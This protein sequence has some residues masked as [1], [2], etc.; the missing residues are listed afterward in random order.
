MIEFSVVDWAA[1]APGLTERSQWMG[2]ADA[3]FL[4]HGEGTPALPEIP[5][6]QRRRIERLGRMAI[7]AA[8]WCEDGQGADSRVP[9]VFASRHG[10]VA[11]SMDL[12]GSLAASEPLSPTG[13]GLSVHNAIAAL[14]SIA[15]GHRGNYLAL[16]AGQATVEAACLEAAGL[17]ADGAPEVR[18]VV[19]ESPLPDVYAEF[20]DEPDPFFAWCWRLAAPGAAG[21]GLRLSWQAAPGAADTAPG[22]LPHALDLQRFLLGGGSSLEHVTQGQRWCWSRRG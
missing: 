10:D 14:Y 7:Q 15:R 8:C 2:W 1:W 4:P 22:L 17:L 19:Y 13:F 6:M 18:I 20:A 21:T 16:A 12:L 3:P 9:L 11:R 5:A